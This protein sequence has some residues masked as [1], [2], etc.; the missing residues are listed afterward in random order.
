MVINK[1]LR[2]TQ[3]LLLTSLLCF[4]GQAMAAQEWKTSTAVSSSFSAS[5]GNDVH[6]RI[7]IECRMPQL[8]QPEISVTLTLADR[9]ALKPN[10]DFTADFV[11]GNRQISLPMSLIGKRYGEFEYRYTAATPLESPELQDFF[12]NVKSLQI[13]A[14]GSPLAEVFHVGEISGYDVEVVIRRCNPASVHARAEVADT[15]NVA[16]VQSL[17]QSADGKCRGGSGDSPLTQ[18]ACDERTEYMD[19][20]KALNMCFGKIGE[21]S[22][23]GQWHRCGPN[24]NR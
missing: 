7:V 9:A 1:L 22:H 19:R 24:S 18:A 21:S 14:K 12:S 16:A 11:A 8:I 17:E 10:A 20:L 2:R 15:N 6:S 13:T 23:Q 5:L 3:F 4:G